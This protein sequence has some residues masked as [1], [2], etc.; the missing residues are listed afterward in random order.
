[1]EGNTMKRFFTLLVLF[2]TFFTILSLK[3]NPLIATY[4]NELTVDPN[5]PYG[6]QIELKS[7]WDPSLNCY[8]VTS[9]GS[10]YLKGNLTYAEYKIIT[11][12]SLDE[13]LA[14]NPAGDT[15]QLYDGY[16]N[17]LDEIVFGSGDSVMTRPPQGAMSISL[18]DEMNNDEQII[19]KY[20]EAPPT[21]GGANYTN[22]HSGY[23][24]GIVQDEYGNPLSDVTINESTCYSGI[25]HYF[26]ETKT[27]T[28]AQGTFTIHSDARFEKLQFNKDGYQTLEIR[29]QIWPDSTVDLGVVILYQ[30]NEISGPAPSIPRS[31]LL[32][33]NS[34]NP[35]NNT[36]RVSFSLPFSDLVR[37]DVFNSNGRLVENLVSGYRHHGVHQF[38]W[39][40]GHLPSGIYL[41][42][43]RTSERQVVVKC[44]LLK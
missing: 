25:S 17:L 36:T 37:I 16:G 27:T 28:D 43:L 10:A 32:I 31:L 8:L 6:W 22:A 12:D 7:P 20:L 29:Q 42:R 14:I 2:F 33:R 34:P 41:L 9:S 18:L 13:S 1:M 3:A 39:Q 19:Y 23:I 35:F 26:N 40:A 15:V 24:T 38:I 4:L 11:S 30:I 44:L 21:L 5:D